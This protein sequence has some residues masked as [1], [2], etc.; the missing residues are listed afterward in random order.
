MGIM[1][2]LVE[3]P[4][5]CFGQKPSRFA[6]RTPRTSWVVG[7]CFGF[8]GLISVACSSAPVSEDLPCC[9]TQQECSLQTCKEHLCLGCFQERC[10]SRNGSAR[11]GEL[12]SRIFFFFNV[13]IFL[14]RLLSS[15]LTKCFF[16]LS[17]QHGPKLFGNSC[18]I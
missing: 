10:F 2:P 12:L 14:E 7:V 17:S 5:L 15:R 3:T 1:N 6:N 4:R 16:L 8:C 9:S 13:S 11:V 18:H